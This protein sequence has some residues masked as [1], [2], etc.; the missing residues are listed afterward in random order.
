MSSAV[1][2]AVKILHGLHEFD[3]RDIYVICAK[4]VSDRQASGRVNPLLQRPVLA[5]MGRIIESN[6]WIWKTVFSKTLTLLEC[7]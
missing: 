7:C 6:E 2:E 3:R 5:G 1:S 4:A